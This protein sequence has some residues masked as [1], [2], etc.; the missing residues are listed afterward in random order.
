MQYLEKMTHVGRTGDVSRPNADVVIAGDP[1]HTNW[2]I[3]ERGGLYCGIWQSTAG[4]WAVSYSEWEYV[5]ILQGY[6]V[7]TDEKGTA[8]HL[9]AG[10][11]FVIR[12]G[13]RGTWTVI[14]T[15]IK[16][17]VIHL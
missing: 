6:S 11:R 7:L 15:T 5:Y 3:E 14:E 4:A 2:S 9:R 17:Y 12:P 8:T 10:D 16:D 1:V 13:F